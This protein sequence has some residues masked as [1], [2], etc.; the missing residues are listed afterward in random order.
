MSPSLKERY[1]SRQTWIYTALGLEFQSSSLHLWATSTLCQ[2][3]KPA[4]WLSTYTITLKAQNEDGTEGDVV[5]T[6]SYSITKATISEDDYSLTVNSDGTGSLT[7]NERI[8]EVEFIAAYDGDFDN[9]D[10]GY[11]TFDENRTC[12]L[13]EGYYILTIRPFKENIIEIEFEIKDGEII[14]Y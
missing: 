9:P 4:L 2:D 10:S 3:A 12:I 6:R 7:I 8:K 13:R 14:Y 1:V 11:L 5:I